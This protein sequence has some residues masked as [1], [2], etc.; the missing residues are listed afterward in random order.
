M[1]EDILEVSFKALDILRIPPAERRAPPP[2]ASHPAVTTAALLHKVDDGATSE[3]NHAGSGPPIPLEQALLC[4]F[5]I[6]YDTSSEMMICYKLYIFSE[7]SNM[8]RK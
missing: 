1:L 3:K 8:L 2:P 4:Y 6:R 7:A 5:Y